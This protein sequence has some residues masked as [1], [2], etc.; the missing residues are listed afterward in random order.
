MEADEL[1]RLL[2]RQHTEEHL[3]EE[4]E[5]GS[6]SSDAQREREND[7]QGKARG[8]AQLPQSV[9]QILKKGL[10]RAVPPGSPLASHFSGQSWT[11]QTA[12][13]K[14]RREWEKTSSRPKARIGVRCRTLQNRILRSAGI[15]EIADLTG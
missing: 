14:K 10:H 9:A 13:K 2:D 7:G 8:F 6:V 4:G 11:A 5:D 15:Q 1:L 3:I 12:D